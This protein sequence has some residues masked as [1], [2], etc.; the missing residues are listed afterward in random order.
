MMME[1]S[2]DNDIEAVG[3]GHIFQLLCETSSKEQGWTRSVAAAEIPGVGC[4]VRMTTQLGGNLSE[5]LAF[6]PGVSIGLD[7]NHGKQLIKV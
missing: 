3:N 7:V 6:V 2:L 1:T 5:A 4:L